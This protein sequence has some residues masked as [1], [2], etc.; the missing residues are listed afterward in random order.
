MTTVDLSGRTALVT[1]GS[2]NVGRGIAHTLARSGCSIA[3]LGGSDASA[4]E[5]TLAELDTLGVRCAGE[6]ADLADADV[7]EAA[8]RRLRDAV[9]PPDILVNNAAIRPHHELEA[10]ATAEWDT[11]LAVNLRAPYLLSRWLIP[12]M[13]ERSFGRIINVSGL[14]AFWGAQG[15]VHVVAAKAGLLGLTRGLAVECGG[16]GVTVNAIVPGVIDTD[17]SGAPEPVR[18]RLDRIVDRVPLGRM[19]T[20]DEVAN[21]CLFLA[22]DLSSYV[23]GE[24]IAV[25][26]GAFPALRPPIE[27]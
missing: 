24:S 5:E 4:L 16:S 8:V 18:R 13:V 3:V 12:E 21:V 10:L 27:S 20:V 7:L 25:S 17:R 11:V 9:G 1:G 2:R 19:G 26:G 6:L 15:K 23:T 22:S 14:D